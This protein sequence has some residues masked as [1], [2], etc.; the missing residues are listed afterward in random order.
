MTRSPAFEV[1]RVRV[2]PTD[3]RVSNVL[4]LIMLIAGSLVIISGVAAS[5]RLF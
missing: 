3:H 1:Y 4:Q 5:L 2:V